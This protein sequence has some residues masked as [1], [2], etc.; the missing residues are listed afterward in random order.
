MKRH[1]LVRLCRSHLSRFAALRATGRWFCQ[2]VL[3]CALCLAGW[4]SGGPQ[5]ANAQT[6]PASNSDIA[7]AQLRLTTELQQQL[8]SAGENESIRVIVLMQAQADL[9]SFAAAISSA[10]SAGNGQSKATRQNLRRQMQT[11]LQTTA[12]ESQR[13]VLDSLQSAL[14]L[15]QASDVRSFWLVNAI[16]LR[17]NPAI[18]RSLAAR[19]DVAHIQL[20]PWRRWINDAG[21]TP[22]SIT[23]TLAASTEITTVRSYTDTFIEPDAISIN[24]PNDDGLYGIQRIRADQVWRGL[25]FTGEGIV[26]ANIDSGVD[27]QH[28]M[29]HA[30]YRGLRTDGSVD[31]LH[32]WFDATPEGATV[33]YDQGGHGTHTMGTI[34]AQD[35]IGVA[36]GAKWIAAKGLTGEG[37]GL[38]SWLLAAMQWMYAPGGDTAYAPDIINNSWG[39]SGTGTDYAFE[40]VLET[41]RSAGI[42]NVWANGNNGPAAKTTNW[43][44]RLAGSFSVGASDAD[45]EIAYFSSRGPGDN[46]LIRPIV[47][48][49]GVRVES[50]YAGG[51]YARYSGTSMATPHVVGTAALLMQAN[52]SLTIDQTIYA[53]T[54]TVKALSTTVPNNESGYGR[55]DAYN[56]VL[57]V[58]STGVITGQVLEGGQPISGAL[59][60]A[61]DHERVLQSLTDAIGRYTIRAPFGFYTATASAFGFASGSAGPRLVITNTVVP[62]NFTLTELPSGVVRGKVRNAETGEVV[63]AT[64]TAL[65]TPKFSLSNN[66]C[67]PCRYSL[68]LP[69]GTYVIQARA[70]GYQ[71]QTQTVTVGNDVLIDL[72]FNLPPTQRIAIMD[73]GASYYGS[74]AQY[75][76]DVLDSLHLAYDY[77]RIKHT[78]ADVPKLAQFYDYDTVIWTSPKDSP[79]VVGAGNVIS[80]YLAAG[81]NMLLSGA[82]VGFFDGGGTVV[83]PYF[84]KFNAVLRGVDLPS[85]V[86]SGTNGPLSSKVI[87][88]TGGDGANNQTQIDSMLLRNADFGTTVGIYPDSFD[89]QLAT[90]RIGAGTYTS[91]CTPY[92]AAF[93]NFGIEAIDNFADRVG[94]ISRTLDA[95]VTPR[96]RYGV[97]LR[98]RDI[99]FS[100]VG[101]ATPG[102]IITHVLRVR[103]TGEAGAAE[104]FT[105][106]L[107]GNQWPTKMSATQVTLAPCE[108]TLI[109]LTTQI[110]LTATADTIDP[111]QVSAN[112][113]H[114]NDVLTFF[115]KTPAHILLVD[116]DLFFDVEQAFID[117]L[118]ANGNTSIDRYSTYFDPN[119]PS[120]LLQ[121]SPPITLMKQYPIVVWFNGYNWFDPINPADQ[122]V[123]RQYLDQGGR[124]FFSSQD[125]L[126]YTQGNWFDQTYLGVGLIDYG[127]VITQITGAPDTG[128]GRDFGPA[129]LSP[130]PYLWNL[131]TAIQPVSDTLVMLR[132]DS[133]QPAGLVHSD[134]SVSKLWKTAFM[135]FAVEVLTD[136]ARA[137]LM[138]RVVGWL[139][140]LGQSSFTAEASHA[141]SG[142][143]ISLTLRLHLDEAFGNT[144]AR[145][146]AISLPLASGLSLVTSPLSD[147]TASNAG[148][149]RGVLHDGET[150][151][152]PLLVRVS[153]G[154][155]SGTL[156]TATV[157]VLIEEQQLHFTRD[158]VVRVNQPTLSSSLNI[159]PA[160]PKWNSTVTATLRI[161]N[162]GAVDAP[163]AKL[164]SI[165]PTGMMLLTNTVQVT[166]PGAVLPITLTNRFAWQGALAAGA[167]ATLT[168]QIAVPPLMR[169][170]PATF[171]HAALLNDGWSNVG[172][173]EVWIA[174][175]TARYPFPIVMR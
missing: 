115:N 58:M 10:M 105:L 85:R 17:A 94:V 102:E 103:H 25:G 47:S 168:Y 164:D 127:D 109:T 104:T 48:A 153:D 20:D 112:S 136:T 40:Q 70:V 84:N 106:T 32:N 19:P 160:T 123:Q 28:P 73:T 42:L 92:H 67:P 116:D 131:S 36:P 88:I 12:S 57:S 98:S 52:P 82:G 44:A 80:D 124:L 137:D 38:L 63:T 72:D 69:S 99:S 138:N 50:T 97:E 172:Q 101:I 21:S 142:E 162:T 173:A 43:P 156:L 163:L 93:Y 166:G 171:Y 132:N 37:S 35:G 22:K 118:K 18:I 143:T 55:I 113:S 77:Y 147:S 8:S 2:W 170:M 29:L 31:H 41:I 86:I 144:G 51:N 155:P 139:S 159:D 60:L 5:P 7:A 71:V 49:P 133:G 45:D 76:F 56:A 65:N 157:R 125:A 154:L 95:F 150:L 119:P 151:T 79:G 4:G 27:W 87:T 175:Y 169:G 100:G 16:A 130:F 15:S 128:L 3:L 167:S 129:P 158:L 120:V 1:R 59:V 117:S 39:S 6:Q 107:Q 89:S 26:V 110:P 91:L 152:W 14:R 62:F 90:G 165:I 145:T 11:S 148:T 75:Y 96:P 68:D 122:T 121:S 135:P 134:V 83:R 74:Q 23:T 33:P 141:R 81:G 146:V 61:Y 46:G 78:P 34:A 54:S 24:I 30:N 114:A 111:I 13:A 126:Q 108:S 64:V 149:W 174:P 66:S 140:P 161:T 9:S 53:L